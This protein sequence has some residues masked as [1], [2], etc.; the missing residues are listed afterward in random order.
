MVLPQLPQQNFIIYPEHFFDSHRVVAGLLQRITHDVPL[1]VGGG[2]PVVLTANG[3]YTGAEAVI[4]KGKTSALLAT[5]VDA[6]L[7]LILTGV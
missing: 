7:L 5:S 1:H 3:L 6:D 4:V 2:I